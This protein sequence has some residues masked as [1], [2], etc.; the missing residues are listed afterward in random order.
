MK[1]QK[2][3]ILILPQDDMLKSVKSLYKKSIDKRWTIKFDGLFHFA[4]A[5][6]WYTEKETKTKCPA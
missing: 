5:Y 4:H 1:S 6:T 3:I 2:S